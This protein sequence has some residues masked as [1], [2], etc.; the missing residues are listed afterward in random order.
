MMS[1]IL[2][3][4]RGTRTGP[5]VERSRGAGPLR[6]FAL[7]AEESVAAAALA[8]MVVLLLVESFV[9][10]LAGLAIPALWVLR[11]RDIHQRPGRPGVAR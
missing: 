8:S 5:A 9:R 6:R 1:T 10:P 11:R 4:E 7:I 2:R 3:G